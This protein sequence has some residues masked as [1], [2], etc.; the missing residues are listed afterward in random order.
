MKQP[1]KQDSNS[2]EQP[3]MRDVGKGSP[4]AK[5]GGR[6]PGN[7]SRK[8]IKLAVLAGVLILILAGWLG[9]YLWTR[10]RVSTDDAFVDGHIYP[11]S[12]RV[13]GY[14]VRVLVEDNQVVRAGE[15]LLV[16]DPTDYEVAVAS[17]EANLAAAQATLKSLELGVPLELSQTQ[18]RVRG[19][20]AELAS[21]RN[22][23]AAAEGEVLAASR[24]LEQV[25]AVRRLAALEFQRVSALWGRKAVAKATLDKASTSLQTARARE[26]AARDRR[27]AAAKKRDALEAALA[28][29]QAGIGLAATGQELASIKSSQVEA[30][31]ARVKLAKARL[32]QA[33]LNLQYTRIK[34]PTHGLVS[35]KSVKPGQVVARGQALMAVVPLSYKEL[36]ITANY[37]ETALA[38]I[39]PG[40]AVRIEVD[41]YPGLELTGRVDSLMAGTGA[42]FSLFPPENATGNYVKVVQRVPVKITIDA[43]EGS[44]PPVLRVG[45]SVVPTVFTDR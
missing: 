14:V 3:E 27:Q 7:G 12:P 40:Q 6:G 2:S 9:Y 29:A 21:L 43:P 5:G 31:R 13:G 19:A 16:L 24:E 10:D 41:A 44:V 28:K 39:R 26:R 35:K 33:R 32:R 34:A 45:M 18:Y 11:I 42:A 23:L 20:K 36:W 38:R 1:T 17:A 22:N 4:S 37:R 30:Q 8:S 15:T 25:T